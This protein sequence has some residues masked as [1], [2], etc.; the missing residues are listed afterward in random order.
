MSAT[1]GP[2]RHIASLDL[3]RGLAAMS[4]LAFHLLRDCPFE[5]V[6][7]LKAMI[8]R[9]NLG[10]EL[11]FFISGFIIPYSMYVNGYS[12]KDFPRYFLKRS[13]RIE[14]PYVASF[15]LVILMRVLHSIRYGDVYVPD[16]T[17]FFLHFP[18][19]AHGAGDFLP[20]Q[21]TVTMAQPMHGDLDRAFAHGVTAGNFG[22][23]SSAALAL[24]MRSGLL[25][26][27]RLAQSRGLPLQLAHH[28][29][30]QSEHP[31][32]LEERFRRASRILN[33]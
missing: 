7:V 16:W 27:G 1:D 30:Q 31:L 2:S 24:Q 21:F 14:I 22:V 12:T 33:R 20:E 18:R 8:D 17:Q 10:L 25:E 19:A 13:C 5:A 26:K 15:L 11:F 29:S 9:G 4:V 6:P 28:L 23:G 3:L 32:P